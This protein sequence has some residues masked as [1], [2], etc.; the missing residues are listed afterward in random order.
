[1]RKLKA[2]SELGRF[3]PLLVSFG[4]FS[5]VLLAFFAGLWLVF[6]MLG[7]VFG[8]FGRVTTGADG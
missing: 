4:R 2:N 8:G 3:W 1:M 6:G 7:P 5:N